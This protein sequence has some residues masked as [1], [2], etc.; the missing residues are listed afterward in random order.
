MEEGTGGSERQGTPRPELAYFQDLFPRLFANAV[1]GI[2]LTTTDGRIYAANPAACRI[3]GRSEAEICRLGRDGIMN[4]EDPRLAAA[5]EERLRTGR[6]HA[7]LTIVRPDGTLATV[8]MTCA[9]LTQPGPG[10]PAVIFFRDVSARV[11]DREA[12]LEDLAEERR[13]AEE[14]DRLLAQLLGAQPGPAP[15][16][17]SA[18]RVLV[19]DDEPLVRRTARRLLEKAGY[20][21][22]EASDGA[23]ALE[24]FRADPAAIDVVLLDLSMPRMSGDEAFAALRQV[25]GDVAVVL[26]SGYAPDEQLEALLRQPRVRFA[27]KPYDRRALGEVI[28]AVKAE[29]PR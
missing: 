1:D 29:A 22:V 18:G 14:Q 12:L 19:V 25:R 9:V 5:L 16:P 11:R 21:V 26:S 28:A 17:G 3:F 27:S 24:R 8:E 10:S 20:A 4:R 13:H 15:A 23:E 6:S 7:E 2:C